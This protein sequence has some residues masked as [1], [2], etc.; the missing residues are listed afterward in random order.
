MQK[1][2]NQNSQIALDHHW[3][4]ARYTVTQDLKSVLSPE[5]FDFC[6]GQSQVL[7]CFLDTFCAQIFAVG[8]DV[9]M[10]VADGSKLSRQELDAIAARKQQIKQAAERFI[11]SRN[12]N[13]ESNTMREIMR[14]VERT[15][16]IGIGAGKLQGPYVLVSR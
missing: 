2:I 1:Q 8:Y 14:V 6:F 9:G 4:D 16:S 12:T 10:F 13:C 15:Y 11:F 5:D 7:N 3:S